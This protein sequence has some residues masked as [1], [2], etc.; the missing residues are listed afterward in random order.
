VKSP[1]DLVQERIERARAK[2][3]EAIQIAKEDRQIALLEILVLARK[4]LT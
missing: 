3:D 2:L 4:D 1:L